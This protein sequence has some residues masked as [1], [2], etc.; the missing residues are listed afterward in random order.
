MATLSAKIDCVCSYVGGT[1]QNDPSDGLPSVSLPISAANS[2]TEATDTH[3]C[4]PV[5]NVVAVN[6]I[7]ESRDG[8]LVQHVCFFVTDSEQNSAIAVIRP[9]TRSTPKMV[10]YEFSIISAPFGSKVLQGFS[11]CLRF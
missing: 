2:N 3:L 11:F 9:S 7:M 8:A 4:A 5:N 10:A 1:L 6:F